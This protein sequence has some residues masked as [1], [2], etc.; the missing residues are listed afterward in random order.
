MQHRTLGKTNKQISELGFGCWAIGGS[1]YGPVNDQDSLKALAFAF[2]HGITFYDT[3]DI[4]GNGHSE[5]LLGETFEGSSKRLQIFIATKA[6]W[7]FYHGGT[8]RNFSPEHIRFACEESLKRLK[9]DHIDLYQLHNPNLKE[10]E[11]KQVFEAL[12]QLKKEGKILHYGVSIHTPEEGLAVVKQ[13]KAETIQAIFNML[14]QRPADELFPET[15][16][17]S[18]G[19]IARE[20]L[21]CG[22]LTGK[23]TKETVFH[24]MDHRNRWPRERYERDLDKV[25]KMCD[26]FNSKRVLLRQAAIEFALSFKSVSVVIPGMKTVQHVEDHL[27]AVEEPGL[28]GK[29]IEKIRDLYLSDP[30]FQTGFF[31]N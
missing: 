23:Y 10:L 28:T 5:R 16:K 25:E 11:D 15:D 20:P 7:D 2:D 24:K 13:G 8:K 26:V 19:I 27:R 31:R 9:T 29:E 30:L 22:V 21:A 14:D 18:I 17:S 1:S 12:D 4:Y 3:A 6:G